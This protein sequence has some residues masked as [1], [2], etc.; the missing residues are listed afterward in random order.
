[1]AAKRVAVITGGASG[2]GEATAR[3]LAA[4]GCAVAILDIDRAGAEA[5]AKSLG[6]HCATCDVADAAAVD[7]AAYQV[8]RELG[9]ADILVTSAGLIPNSEAIMEMDMGSHARMREVNYN[10][11]LHACRAFGR[12]MIARKGGAIVTLAPSTAAFRC[13]S[14]PTTPAR[15][16]SSD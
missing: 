1:M 12:Q 14:P 8:E 7:A 10:G 11:T 5:V 4:D 13:R 6:G 3:R 2:I 9:P 16:P 15:L